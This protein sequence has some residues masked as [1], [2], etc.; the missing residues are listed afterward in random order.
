MVVPAGVANGHKG[1]AE[2]SLLANVPDISHDKLDADEMIR[3]DPSD[4][5]IPYNWKRKDN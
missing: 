5:D 3:I 2:T 1:I 4:N